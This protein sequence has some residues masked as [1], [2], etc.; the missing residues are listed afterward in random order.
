MIWCSILS[1]NFVGNVQTLPAVQ[2][3]LCSLDQ[4]QI[5]KPLAPSIRYVPIVIHRD[6]LNAEVRYRLR[7]LIAFLMQLSFDFQFP[8][9]HARNLIPFLLIKANEMH[10]FST[11][12]W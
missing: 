8:A 7:P 5:F 10:Y 3:A 12:F 4:L 1:L 11:L 6:A 9:H 2:F